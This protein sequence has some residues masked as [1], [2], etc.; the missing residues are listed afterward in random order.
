MMIELFIVYCIGL[1]GILV[2]FYTGDTDPKN[3]WEVLGAL[4]VAILWPFWIFAKL[5]HILEDI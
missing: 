3:I 2:G 4:T 1:I 5:T